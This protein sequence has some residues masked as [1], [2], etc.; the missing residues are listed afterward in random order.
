MADL[1]FWLLGVVVAVSLPDM[2]EDFKTMME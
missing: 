2:W 1:C